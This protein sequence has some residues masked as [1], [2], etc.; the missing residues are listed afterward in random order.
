MITVDLAVLISFGQLPSASRNTGRKRIA[1]T[2]MVFARLPDDNK[3]F[4]VCFCFI[5]GDYID[6]IYNNYSAIMDVERIK[7]LIP[8]KRPSRKPGTANPKS[9][10]HLQPIC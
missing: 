4:M 9:K 1:A 6:A 3:V 8:V 10:T 2:N 7:R 5:Y